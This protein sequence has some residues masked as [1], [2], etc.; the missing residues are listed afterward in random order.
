VVDIFASNRPSSASD[1]L[2]RGAPF[3]GSDR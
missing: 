2:S 3:P 1:V